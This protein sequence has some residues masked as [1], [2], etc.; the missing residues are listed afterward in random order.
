MVIAYVKLLS[1]YTEFGDYTTYVF[2]NLNTGEYLICTKLPRWE[3]I[4]INIGD[5]GFLQ[6]LEVIAGKTVWYDK[7]SEKEINYKYSGIYFQK[8]IPEIKNTIKEIVL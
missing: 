2:E 1:L 5:V 8:F 3:S 7:L 4:K 6:Y